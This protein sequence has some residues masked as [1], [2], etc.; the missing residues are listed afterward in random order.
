[1]G[2]MLFSTDML[3]QDF[4]QPAQKAYGFN[5]YDKACIHILQLND[6]LI[7]F[8]QGIKDIPDFEDVATDIHDR[9]NPEVYYKNYYEKY[10]RLLMKA[11]GLYQKTLLTNIKLSNQFG[12][13]PQV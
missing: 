9:L 5:Q 7:G 2:S 1:M 3:L 4:I 11:L 6:F 10:S 8:G 13:A 12:V